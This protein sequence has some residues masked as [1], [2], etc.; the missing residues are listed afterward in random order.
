MTETGL[1][2]VKDAINKYFSNGYIGMLLL[3]SVAFFFFFRSRKRKFVF[4]VWYS[5]L[6][7][8]FVLNP[9]IA[10][11]LSK[12]G[13]D[14]VHWRVFWFMPAGILIC[15]M[16]VEVLSYVKSKIFKGVLVVV[17]CLILCFS[18]GWMY[19]RGNFSMATNLYKIPQYILDVCEYIPE[20]SRIMGDD[21]VM[22]WIRTYDATIDM[23]YGR[24]MI[25]FGGY[26]KQTELRNLWNA[27]VLDVETLSQKAINYECDYIVYGKT[28][29]VSDSWE[30]YGMKYVGETEYYCVYQVNG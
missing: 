1:L 5:V 28:K 8:L 29:N 22:I 14:L 24:Q 13:M 20:N 27:E 25:F 2:I 17:L 4:I 10:V 26:E 9:I 23:P 7:G 12:L 21:N 18:G 16:F 19:V 11:I 6:Y 15:S 30:N 3:V